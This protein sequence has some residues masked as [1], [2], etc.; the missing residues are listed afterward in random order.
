MGFPG[1]G[2]NIGNYARMALFKEPYTFGSAIIIEYKMA[3]C[4]RKTIL[5]GFFVWNA[6][7]SASLYL[8][9]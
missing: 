3:N 4:K 2:I 8:K 6:C 5:C 1:I 9:H 7:G